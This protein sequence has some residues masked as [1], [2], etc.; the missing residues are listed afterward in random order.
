MNV[1]TPI[2]IFAFVLL[3]V[4][5]VFAQ[6]AD[7]LIWFAAPAERFT[8]NL[9]LGNRRLGATAWVAEML[10]QNHDETIRLLP[11]VPDAWPEGSVKGLAGR[12]GFVVDMDWKN[13]KLTEARIFFRLGGNAKISYAEKAIELETKKG[14]SYRLVGDFGKK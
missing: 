8:E 4:F 3:C 2:R 1:F 10:L 11:A 6:T 14:G 7:K 13:G 5:S 12:G 9:P